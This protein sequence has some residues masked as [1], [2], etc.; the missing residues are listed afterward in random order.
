[1]A[2]VRLV[3]IVGGYKFHLPTCSCVRKTPQQVVVCDR[4]EVK[5]ADICSACQRQLPFLDQVQMGVHHVIS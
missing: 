2:T 5:A 3:Q 4:K 1:M